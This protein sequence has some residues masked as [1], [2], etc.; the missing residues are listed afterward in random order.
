MEQIIFATFS[1]KLSDRETFVKLNHFEDGKDLLDYV[2]RFFQE[3]YSG[4]L[5]TEEYKGKKKF[6]LRAD[7]AGFRAEQDR[8]YYGLLSSGVSGDS[9]KIIELQTNKKKADVGAGDG[10]FK[11]IFFFFISQK[12]ERQVI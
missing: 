2:E 12:I 7:S 3:I 4:V 10:A 11:D 5:K 8:C 6:H 9:Y 1:I